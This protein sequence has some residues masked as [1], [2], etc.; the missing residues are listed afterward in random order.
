MSRRVRRDE[1][2]VIVGQADIEGNAAAKERQ[3]VAGESRLKPKAAEG[4]RS[5]ARFRRPESG[6]A[7]V[8]IY[9]GD[10]VVES[11]G[12]SQAVPAGMGTQMKEGQPPTEPEQLLPAVQPSSPAAESEWMIGDPRFSWSAVDGASSYVLE[13]CGDATCGRL[14]RRQ[15]G[16]RTRALVAAR[17]AGRGQL[18]LAGYGG[19]RLGLSTAIRARRR[20]SQFSLGRPRSGA[21]G[22]RHL[23]LG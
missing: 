5:K 22:D 4:G 10:S 12:A 3:L 6:G 18:P 15:T 20:R 13:I 21:A 9:A 11:G 16:I 7:Q 8:M 17:G 14:V 23:L 1:I 19:E 2:E